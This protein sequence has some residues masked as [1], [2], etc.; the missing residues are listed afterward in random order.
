VVNVVE[1]PIKCPVAPLEFLMLA[2]WY[3]HKRGIRDRVELIYATPLGRFHQ[4]DRIPLLGDMLVT[5]GI[6]VIAR[7]HGRTRRA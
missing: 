2:D 6:E 5:K 3:F 1:N 4:T 7:I